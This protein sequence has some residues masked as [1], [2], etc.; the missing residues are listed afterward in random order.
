MVE[1]KKRGIFKF[2][3]MNESTAMLCFFIFYEKQKST[4]LKVWLFLFTYLKG[5]KR[6]KET[7][8]SCLLI[9][10][11]ILTELWELKAG[12]RVCQSQRKKF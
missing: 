5:K 9:W 12:L 8:S 2:K 11:S 1:K 3:K 10:Y 7:E 6:K 4:L